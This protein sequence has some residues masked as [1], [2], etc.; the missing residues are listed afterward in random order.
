MIQ[1]RIIDWDG[2]VFLCNIHCIAQTL[3][4]RNPKNGSFS[5]GF[6]HKEVF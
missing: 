5:C 4:P 6:D 2:A 1:D 3:K